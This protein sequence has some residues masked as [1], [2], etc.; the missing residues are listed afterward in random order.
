MNYL[1]SKKILD[2]IRNNN[3][4][5]FRMCVSH[6]MDVGIRHLTPVDVMTT[7]KAITAQDD[8]QSAMSNT[9]QC[10]IVETAGEIAK[11]DHIH[12]LVYIQDEICYDVGQ[13]SLQKNELLDKLKNAIMWLVD[14]CCTTQTAY[15][16]LKNEWG[17]NDEE[18]EQ[19]GFDYLI[20]ES[21]LE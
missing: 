15:S 3:E 16:K 5:L 6:L 10:Q 7:C 18:L 20:P 9:F 12:L 14:D 11:I 8:T 1:E 19:L 2:G 17:L 4:I 13:H 21:I